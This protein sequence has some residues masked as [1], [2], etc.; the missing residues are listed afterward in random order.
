MDRRQT[1][2]VQRALLE[3]ELGAA[4]ARVMLVED[5]RHVRFAITATFRHQARIV[6]YE[7]I[8]EAEAHADE[9]WDGRIIDRRL[10]DGD[11]LAFAK[12]LVAQDPLASVVL[13]TATELHDVFDET[14]ELGIVC[15]QKPDGIA[16]LK[17][18]VATWERAA[19]ASEGVSPR[20]RLEELARRVEL[21]GREHDVAR[22]AV[23]GLS[24]AAAAARLGIGKGTHRTHV[25]AVL[26]KTGHKRLRQL[27]GWLS[28]ED[29]DEKHL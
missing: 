19:R 20:A 21:T 28:R 24:N 27:V 6:A 15:A 23:A 25:G 7:T 5:D 17:R 9:H 10:P 8:R 22:L 2:G 4:V 14:N 26:K 13:F 3:R 12:R 29:H 11:G 16:T 18:M 1:H